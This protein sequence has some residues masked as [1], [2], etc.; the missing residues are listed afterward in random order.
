MKMGVEPH[1]ILQ[2]VIPIVL[3]INICIIDIETS[4]VKGLSDVET[5]EN[6]SI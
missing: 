5:L 6:N 1:S 2:R 3:R 4:R